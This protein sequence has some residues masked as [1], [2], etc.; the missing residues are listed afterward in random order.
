MATKYLFVSGCPRSGTTV[1]T[2]MLNWADDAFV[3]QERYA[4]LFNK[5]PARFKPDLFEGERMA[6][7]E[8]GDCAKHQFDRDLKSKHARPKDFEAI[9]S[10][11][12]RGDKITNLYTRFGM[13]GR[14][15]WIEKDVTVLHIVRNLGDVAASYHTRKLNEGDRWSRDYEKAIED[16]SA[17]V[18]KTHAYLAKPATDA[19]IGIVDYDTLFTGDLKQLMKG[20]RAIYRFAGLDFTPVQRQGIR[21]LHV[22]GEKKKQKRQ[23]HDDIR[24]DAL[25]RVDPRTL[26]R[27]QALVKRAIR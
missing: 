11:G 15:E 26:E 19:R 7:H 22:V 13:F 25:A 16:W 18:D 2:H 6:R 8:K 10:Y 3:G 24:E 4:M 23:R 5:R 9:D 12:H 27:Y 17:S 14:G 1:L 21:K 20:A